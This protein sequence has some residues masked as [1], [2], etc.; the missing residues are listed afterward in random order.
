MFQFPTLLSLAG[1]W[2]LPQSVSGF[3]HLRVKVCLATHRSFSQLNHVLHQLWTPRHPP[4]TLSNLPIISF[5]VR[6]QVF[7]FTLFSKINVKGKKKP[8]TFVSNILI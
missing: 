1:Y 4:Y 7:Q 6:Y 5:S 8:S 2:G 3:G